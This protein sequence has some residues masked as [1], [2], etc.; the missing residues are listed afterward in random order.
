M[1]NDDQMKKKR[2]IMG[3][4][5]LNAQAKLLIT[6]PSYTSLTQDGMGDHMLSPS[7]MSYGHNQRYGTKMTL[8]ALSSPRTNLVDESISLRSPPPASKMVPFELQ[9]QMKSAALANMVAA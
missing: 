6:Q 8:P 5:N 7:M 4:R 1:I 2:Q 3:S 9:P